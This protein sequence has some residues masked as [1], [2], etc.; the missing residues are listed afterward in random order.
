MGAIA[1]GDSPKT[2]ELFRKILL[3]SA[4]IPIL[5]SPVYIPVEAGGNI[6]EEMHVDSEVA[7][8]VFFYGDI[9]NLEEVANG[10][11]LS[12]GVHGRIYI[13]QNVQAIP[14]YEPVKPQLI[15]IA[16]KAIYSLLANQGIGDIFRI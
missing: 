5:L 13:I 8:Q 7:A 6:Y 16:K 1:A 3:A 11:G 9:L 10:A 14:S 15:P 12:S 4:S 2:E